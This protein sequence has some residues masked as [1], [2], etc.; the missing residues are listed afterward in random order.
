VYIKRRMQSSDAFRCAF[1]ETGWSREGREGVHLLSSAMTSPGAWTCSRRRR[2]R[3]RQGPSLEPSVG[4]K[5]FGV[6]TRAIGSGKGDASQ[7]RP[8]SGARLGKSGGAL[9]EALLAVVG[10]RVP[11]AA[12]HQ[13]AL[14]GS[15]ES[16]IM[17]VHHLP[18]SAL[19]GSI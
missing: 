2:R 10:D 12:L 5:M 13:D 15:V 4:Q 18:P 8:Q 3:R 6:R 1:R 16:S 17:T 7:P 19:R 11:L 14:R 9:A